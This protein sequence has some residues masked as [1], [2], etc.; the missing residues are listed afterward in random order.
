MLS[1]SVVVVSLMKTV[2]DRLTP[3]VALYSTIFRFSMGD[4]EVANF[5]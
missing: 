3:L 2:S 4:F 1:S 5:E